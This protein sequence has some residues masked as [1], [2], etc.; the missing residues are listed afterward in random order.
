MCFCA[1]R[2]LTHR[3]REREGGDA[4]AV[5]QRAT[6]HLQHSGVSKSG[7]SPVKSLDVGPGVGVLIPDVI[8][9][10]ATTQPVNAGLGC[11]N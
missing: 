10:M 7:L 9:K 2:D 1:H 3:E 5:K 6:L 8:N 4:K 11:C